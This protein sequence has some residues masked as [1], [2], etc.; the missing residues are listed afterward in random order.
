MAD[1]NETLRE[2]ERYLDSELPTERVSEIIGHLK[3]C[4]D[5][6]SAYEFHA[7]LRTTIRTKA[8]RDE[9][10]DGFMDRLATCLGDDLMG[11]E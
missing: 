6:Q 7:E 8:L 11:A 10:P 9:L 2:L 5:C 4:T 3:G 1:C